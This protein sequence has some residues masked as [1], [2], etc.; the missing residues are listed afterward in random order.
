MAVEYSKGKVNISP[1]EK[2]RLIP[3]DQIRRTKTE[4]FTVSSHFQHRHLRGRELSM[5]SAV[6]VTLRHKGDN[7][8]LRLYPCGSIATLISLLV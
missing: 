4:F 6:S 7:I 3:E 1:D 8:S 5:F 2:T